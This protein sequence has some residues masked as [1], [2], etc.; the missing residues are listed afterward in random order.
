MLNRRNIDR[1]ASTRAAWVSFRILRWVTTAII[2]LAIAL[3]TSV[4]NHDH[5]NG[6]AY[7]NE[8][9]F[10]QEAPGPLSGV[11][12]EGARP[13]YGVDNVVSRIP[14]SWSAARAFANDDL[15]R[16]RR[17]SQGVGILLAGARPGAHAAHGDT[18]RVSA[19]TRGRSAVRSEIRRQDGA[20]SRTA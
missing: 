12:Y 18:G 11:V 6:A 19:R 5:A 20:E 7:R 14:G 15:E 13:R 17:H 16:Q 1:R 9:C 8:R 10:I 2:G 4:S 3:C